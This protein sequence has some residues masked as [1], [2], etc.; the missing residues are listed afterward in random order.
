MASRGVDQVGHR[1][2]VK[3]EGFFGGVAYVGSHLFASV[4]W[5]GVVLE[6]KRLGRT[7]A[8]CRERDTLINCHDN[9]GIFVRQ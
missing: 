1:V 8:A 9:F 4:K 5:I 7:T 3:D 6:M 2:Q